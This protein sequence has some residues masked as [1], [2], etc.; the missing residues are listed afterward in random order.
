[1]RVKKAGLE[2]YRIVGSIQSCRVLSTWTV[3]WSQTPAVRAASRALSVRV[4]GLGLIH[5]VQGL[6]FRVY[7]VQG[8]GFIGFRV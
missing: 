2:V 3:S 5:R 1:M 8:S 6:G 4:S 7:R